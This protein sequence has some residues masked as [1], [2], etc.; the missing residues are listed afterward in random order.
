MN[1]HNIKPTNINNTLFNV[2]STNEDNTTTGKHGKQQ[3]LQ[4][5]TALLTDQMALSL[6]TYKFQSLRVTHLRECVRSLFYNIKINLPLVKIYCS[7]LL[8]N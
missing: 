4:N 7:F 2:L 5:D 8:S 3:N 6:V 1:N